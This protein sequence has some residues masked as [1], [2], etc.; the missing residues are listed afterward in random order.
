MESFGDKTV[1]V[2]PVKVEMSDIGPL[3]L[4]VVKL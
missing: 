2:T 1:N 3:G 4:T